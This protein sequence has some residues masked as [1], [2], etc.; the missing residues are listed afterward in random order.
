MDTG[1]FVQ[2]YYAGDGGP[3]R[4][5]EAARPAGVAIRVGFYEA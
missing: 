3:S 1:V 4:R 5:A 2:S